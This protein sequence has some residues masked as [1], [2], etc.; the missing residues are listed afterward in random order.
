MRVDLVTAPS[1]EPVTLDEM[2]LYLKVDTDADDS[3]IT[4]LIK[5][6]RISAEEITRRA[7][8]TQ[9]VRVWFKYDELE[10][11]LEL[12]FPP[13][14]EVTE[15]V[16]ST[17]TSQST[18]DADNYSYED[19]ERSRVIYAEA[20]ENWPLY[21]TEGHLGVKYVCGY[22][23]QASDVPDDIKQAIKLIVAHWYE[24]RESQKLP[25]E[26]VNI[27]SKKRIWRL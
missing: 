22:G 23:D 13:L 26:A 17:P 19:G 12:P 10:N 16:I 7:F 25:P 24:N 4:S 3:Y 8:I 6:A 5:A 18:V 15:I 9:T 2:K 11:P 14:Q 20:E 1:V 27:L 21:D